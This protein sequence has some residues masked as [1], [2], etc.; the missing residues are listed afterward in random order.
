MFSAWAFVEKGG[1]RITSVVTCSRGLVPRD[2]CRNVFPNAL[3]PDPRED[4]KS[5]CHNGGSYKVPLVV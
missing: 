1:L 5:R 2:F 3:S 4:L